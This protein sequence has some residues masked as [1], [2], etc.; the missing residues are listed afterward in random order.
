ME[1]LNK[2]KLLN[3]DQHGV[4]KGKSCSTAMTILLDDTLEAM[5][6]KETTLAVFIDFKKAFDPI[7][8]DRLLIKLDRIGLDSNLLNLIKHYLT[9]KHKKQL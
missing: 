8:H 1:H 9:N 4:R 3:D 7:D 5:G 6:R 2:N